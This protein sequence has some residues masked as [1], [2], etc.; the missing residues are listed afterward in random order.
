MIP[1]A[2]ASPSTLIMVRKRS[3]WG[4]GGR[5]AAR[6]RHFAVGGAGRGPQQHPQ[7]DALLSSQPTTLLVMLKW[8]T[9]GQLHGH[10][11]AQWLR[12][13]FRRAWAWA[14]ALLPPSQKSSQFLN[15]ESHIVVFGSW[16][17]QIGPPLGRCQGVPTVPNHFPVPPEGPPKVGVGRQGEP[18][19]QSPVDSSDEGDVVGRKTHGSEHDDHGDKS[20]LG[21][22]GC[23]DTGR[24]GCDAAGGGGSVVGPWSQGGDRNAKALG[25]SIVEQQLLGMPHQ[26]ALQAGGLA[27]LQALWSQKP[28]SL[29]SAAP[30]EKVAENPASG[31]MLSRGF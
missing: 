10:V 2:R 18:H 20:G 23:P 17:P 8:V 11:T 3:L 28:L 14:K 13:V 29:V 30:P 19:L 5:S 16:A 6:G 15:P 12:P 7:K 27:L 21:D 4:Q 25:D 22:A 26:G 31:T 24:G 9:Q 1:A